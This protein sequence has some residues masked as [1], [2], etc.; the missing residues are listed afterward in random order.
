MTSENLF[1]GSDQDIIG[2]AVGAPT[3]NKAAA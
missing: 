3:Q 1:L 2:A